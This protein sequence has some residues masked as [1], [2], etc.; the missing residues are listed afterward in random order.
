MN[1]RSLPD[2]LPM[3]ARRLGDR[4]ALRRKRWG[5]YED[6]SWRRYAESVG[7]LARGLIELGVKPGQAVAVWSEN[8]LEWLLADNAILAVGAVTVPLHASLP[9]GQL[10][11]PLT[12]AEVQW[13][14]VASSRQLEQVQELRLPG[15]RGILAFEDVSFARLSARGQSLTTELPGARPEDLATIMYTSGTTGRPKGVMLTHANLLSNAVAYAQAA[16]IASDAVVLNWLPLSH[17]F[18]RTVEHYVHLV[19]GSTLCLAESAESVIRNLAEIA[20]THF[21]SVPR[22]YEKILGADLRHMFGPRLRWL[23]SGGAPLPPHVAEAFAQAGLLVLPGYGLTESS[24][25]IALNR[26]DCHRAGTVGPALPGVEIRIAQDGEILTRGSHVMQGYWKQP[27]ETDE[28]LRDGWLATGDLGALDADGFL[29]ITGRKKDLIVLS[30]GKKV[31]PAY[32]EAK[33]VADPDIDQA[34]VFGD[35][36]SYLTALLVSALTPEQLTERVRILLADLAPWEQVKRFAV[37]TEPFSVARDEMTV[38]LKLRRAAIFARHR[39][40]IDAL[41]EL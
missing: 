21:N 30:S 40:K 28:V 7:S 22:F 20:P 31:A 23:G 38:S 5:R 13:I 12:D 17:I 3:Q 27:T 39:A 41:Y 19:A 29:S 32:L 2:L 18:A 14:F 36:R 16:Q 24:P 1:P 4:P 25:V 35:G 10:A 37:L 9:P 34:V 26:P 15:L 33:L 11:F 8:R 6:I